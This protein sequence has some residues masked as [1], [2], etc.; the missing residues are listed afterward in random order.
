MK[1]KWSDLKVWQWIIHVAIGAAWAFAGT[2]IIWLGA[3]VPVALL[4]GLWS[5]LVGAT[6]KEATDQTVYDS[7]QELHAH[8]S[9][10]TWRGIP[11]ICETLG[12]KGWDWKDYLQHVVGGFI[13]PWVHIWIWST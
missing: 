13:A 7:L 12:W 6:M 3:S 4:V 11:H 8:E 5:A 9:M 10:T 1:K 2:S